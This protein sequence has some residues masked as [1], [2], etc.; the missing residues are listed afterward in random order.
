MPRKK[1]SSADTTP[2]A[3]YTHQDK[4]RA[5]NPPVG[6][7][8]PDTDQE[9]A[10]KTYAYDPHLDPQL[11][12]AGKAEHTSFAI[13]TVSRHVH[14][15]IDPRT[16]IEAVRK[17]FPKPKM[18]I[19]AAFQFDPE[20]AKDIEE[21]NWPGVTLL[22]A[23]MNADLLTDD[24]KKKRASNESFWLIGQPDVVVKRIAPLGAEGAR[25]VGLRLLR[26]AQ[27]RERVGRHVADCVVDVGHGLRRAQF[28]AASGVLP[29][30][31]RER[32]LGAAG[33]KPES[34]N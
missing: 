9:G 17:L 30:G 24:L 3:Q 34:R 15:R 8:T 1:A 14:E 21:T 25:S 33:Q 28:V 5:N 32:R 23:Q 20:A 26:H 2:L 7:V 31:R 27:R 10:Q 29:A 11:H 13:P 4:Q 18:L 12:W 16:I 19:F 6:L 22:K